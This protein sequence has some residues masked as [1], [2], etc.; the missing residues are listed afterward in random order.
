MST[1]FVIQPFDG[2]PYDKRYDDVFVPAIESTGLH[3][4]RVD[5]DPS[6]SIPIDQ[7]ESGIRAAVICLA[8]ITE[9]N[10]NVWFELGYAIAARIDVILV[11]SKQRTKPFPFD[12]QHR[13]IIRYSTESS[14]DFE[15]L[16]R[17]I[18]ERIKAL[19]TK[20]EKLADVNVSS[21]VADVEGLSQHEM[22]A[23]LAIAQ[24][25]DT[26]SDNVSIYS[27]Q[28]DMEK[29]GFTKIATT[30]ALTSLLHKG[31]IRNIESQNWRGDKYTAYILKNPGINWL[32]SNQER[33][34]L[35]RAPEQTKK[36]TAHDDGNNLPF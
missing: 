35:R 34:I 29:S 4:Y 2:G 11:C 13:K 28:Q 14:R 21:P 24:N 22:V 3:P 23:L 19:L 20:L 33:F 30:L 12:V 25:L 9:D 26:P 36:A 17:G 7:I 1:C 18:T 16:K 10:P 31:F 27:I 8:D 6:V 5:R 15:E 32:L